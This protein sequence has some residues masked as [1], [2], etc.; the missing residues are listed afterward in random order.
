MEEGIDFE[1]KYCS[2]F[3]ITEDEFQPKEKFVAVRETPHKILETQEKE[4][5]KSVRPNSILVHKT[6]TQ[7]IPET[8]G[9]DD[10][11]VFPETQIDVIVTDS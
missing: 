3:N 7:V 2:E 1:V 6:Q 9:L 5:K 10:I 11:S 4:D 8:Q